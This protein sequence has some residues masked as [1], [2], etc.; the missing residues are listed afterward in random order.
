MRLGYITAMAPLGREE[1][2]VLCEMIALTELGVDLVITPR[3][4]SKE[5]F[6]QEGK[7]LLAQTVCQ[8]LLSWQMLASLLQALIRK[9]RT[10]GLMRTLVRSSRSASI[11]GKNLGVLPKAV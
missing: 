6:H 2:F 1:T 7:V 3:S 11:L 9:P 4:P 10:L 5:L 8:P